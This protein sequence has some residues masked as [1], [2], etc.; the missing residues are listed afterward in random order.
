LDR[1]PIKFVV[2]E[3]E[4][5]L[6]A[7]AAA[8]KSEMFISQIAAISVAIIASLQQDRKNLARVSMTTARL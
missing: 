5:S 8:T 1:E 3:L 4:E 7:T 2:A 6:A